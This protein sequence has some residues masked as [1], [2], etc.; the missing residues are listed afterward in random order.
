LLTTL[1]SFVTAT[2]QFGAD[3]REPVLFRSYRN[4]LD[5]NEFPD[6]KIW[7]A[8][9]ATSAAPTVFDPITVD[10]TTFLD[11]GIHANNPIGW[12]ALNQPA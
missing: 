2:R 3:S 5:K 10:N 9:R 8:A 4:P 7:E 6:I 1:C 11:G 12:Y